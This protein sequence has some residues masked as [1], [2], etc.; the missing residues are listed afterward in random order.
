[1]V[2]PTKNELFR[3]ITE[4]QNLKLKEVLSADEWLDH[5]ASPEHEELLHS[6]LRPLLVAE[7]YSTE[8]VVSPLDYGPDFFATREEEDG[9]VFQLGV[10]QK[11][12]SELSDYIAYY[13][14]ERKHSALDY[15]TPAQFEAI[16]TSP[17]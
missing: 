15:L 9:D 10:Q 11:H 1:M 12:Y 5:I 14:L 17:N 6:I 8:H 16:H 4:L 13:N 3:K 2:Q 7:G